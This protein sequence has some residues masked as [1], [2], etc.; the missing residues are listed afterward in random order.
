MLKTQ[1]KKSSNIDSARQLFLTLSQT[2]LT[3]H[4]VYEKLLSEDKLEHLAVVLETHTQDVNKGK[5]IHVYLSYVKKR[6]LSL[7]HFDFLQNGVHVEKVKNT[8]NLLA[9][10][11]KENE[12]KANFD[13]WRKL[14][15]SRSKFAQTLARMS[16]L[17]YDLAEIQ[18]KYAGELADKPWATVSRFVH[19]VEDLKSNPRKGLDDQ[20]RWIDRALI[21][22]R[23]TPEELQLFDSDPQFQTLVDYI[24][25]VKK[26]GSAQVHKECCLAI[27]SAPSTGKT[28][29]FVK[30]AEHYN[31]YTFPADGWHAR[32]YKENFYS[33]WTW[34]EWS[35]SDNSMEDMLKLTEGLK[36]DLR[37]KGSKTFKADRPMLFLL[38]NES[39]QD[40]YERRFSYLK[41]QMLSTY[42]VRRKA[43][44][45]RI[46][47][48][49][50]GEKNL[51]F[52]Q[53]LFV[54]LS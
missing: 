3:V 40:K 6:D 43:F 4:E 41:R 25:K 22:E 12:C 42:E 44:A 38:D 33:M 15:A 52:L 51:F 18:V 24:N 47:E 13:V 49:N 54:P 30:L 11:S 34:N 32:R 28:S 27:V 5:H 10:M 45:V 21:E 39:W 29:L 19:E 35:F 31:N 14:L 1:K 46:R 37:V 7:R 20:L 9:Y 53:K 23:L 48:L 17:G 8:E 50:F 36:T 16:E 2:N 26:F